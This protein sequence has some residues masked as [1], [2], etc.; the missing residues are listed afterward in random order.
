MLQIVAGRS[1]SGK[2]EWV[3]ERIAAEAD[4]KEL[5]LL[6]PEQISFQN[7]QRILD[8]L[9]AKTA[10]NILVLSFRKLYQTV[11]E[12]YG[13]AGYQRIDDG[14][15]AVLMNLAAEEVSDRLVLYHTRCQKSDFTELMLSAVNEYKMCAISPE[16]L[17][18]TAKNIKERRLRQKLEE[19][20]AVYAAYNA[21]LH[22]A[23]ADPDDDMT[24]LYELLCE[25]PYF[26][27]KTVYVDSFNGFSGQEMKVLECI[28]RQADYVGVTLGC[29]RS[30]MQAIEHSIF[31]EPDTTR[32]Q[33]LAMAERCGV[34][35]METVWLEQQRRFRS[36]SIAA[37]EESLFR[38]DGDPYLPEDQ[39]VVLYEAEDE[40]D[41]VRQAA[42]EISR[43]V[44]DE[45]YQY[46]E[47]AVIFRQADL[48]KNQ[49][50][51]EFPKFRIPF[52]LSNPEKLEEKP[53]IRLVLS[54]FDVVH[55]SF[56]TEDIFTFLKTGLSPLSEEET[57]LLEN[58]V[59]LW[60]IRGKRWKSPFT[61]NPEG[62]VEKLDETALARLEELRQRLMKP[63]QM[64]SDELGHARNGADLSKAVYLLLSRCGAA[65]R[66]KQ[67]VH[68][69]DEGTYL[70]AKET[71]ARIWDLLMNLLD[72]MY[73]ILRN[74]SLDSR[75][76]LELFRLMIRKNQISDIPQ[77]LDQV[78]IGT[79][80]N[81]KSQGQRA[82]FVL[83]AMEGVFPAIPAAKG[84]FSDSERMLLIDRELPLYDTVYGMSLKEKYFVYDALTLPSE[85]LYISRYLSDAK[86]S[87]CEPSIIW[88]EVGA[89]LGNAVIRHH[90]DLTDR[91][92]YFTEEQVFEE[93]AA[94]WHENSAASAAMKTYFSGQPAFAGRCDAI[95]RAVTDEP[96]RITSDGN[97]RKLFG[98]KL[99]LSAS[100][101]EIY[102]LCPFR[103]FCQ[104]GL[105]AYPRKRASM[106][107]GMYG[108]AVHFILERL[109][110]QEDITFL[111]EAGHEELKELIHRYLL[112]YLQEI[113]GAGERTQR[114]MAQLHT[115]EKN[116]SLLLTRLIDEFRVSQ[117]I[118]ADYELS[119][120]EGGEIPSYELEL[121]DG[122]RVSVIGKV[123][124]VD[125]YVHNGQKYL[126]IIDY[127]TGN[128]KFRLSDVLYG[129]NL[130]MLLYLSVLHQKGEAYYSDDQPYPLMPAGILYMPSTPAAQTAGFHS[131]NNL[132]KAVQ[133]QQS[134]FKMNGLLLYDKEILSAMEEGVKGIYIPARLNAKG[135]LEKRYSSVISLEEYGK[136]FSYIDH[137]LIRMAQSLKEG[138]VERN[139]LKGMTDACQYC[140]YQSVCGFEKGKSC[141]SAYSVS[142]DD[143]MTIM[144]R[145]EESGDE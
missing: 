126:R 49:I 18:E 4:R 136:V 29:D 116:L 36:P 114:F 13:G 20:A 9:G 110:R 79:A 10:K 82:V 63:L 133:E 64:F 88:K 27:G 38:F 57:D 102:H 66:M 91:E 65:D 60:D 59:Y 104:Y 103:Y 23:Y 51:T 72:K 30:P 145:E 3:H 33:L 90:D 48:Y 105:R 128:K 6:V 138:K 125:T 52:F 112:D 31:K 139:P 15:K 140:D 47:I 54:A 127:K 95:Q 101:T 108:S 135:D 21:L 37:I 46:R 16:L 45:H 44:R 120:G 74:T 129:L 58:Y 134:N 76:Y 41:E 70:K 1:G 39:G 87:R 80:G 43:L 7:E 81:F 89:I 144:S 24:R 78:M 97:V 68:S 50:L 75:R 11:T 32:L 26:R 132:R 85:R 94:R 56:R 119:I 117:F 34:T 130:Q 115:I 121:P 141:H 40:Y 12:Q 111:K 17:S 86:G 25:N 98:D 67:Y 92:R 2:T 84:L 113:G 53:L 35:V 62:N 73:T 22:E 122:E 19:S 131:D 69:I 93:C 96:Y 142:M 118:P 107:A 5:I 61:M 77:T 55:S 8:T 99:S 42:R 109:L 124:R 14:A 71:E 123:D 83:G 28:I 143:A 137:K 106:D 100:Q